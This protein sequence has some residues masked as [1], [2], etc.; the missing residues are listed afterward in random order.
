M[1]N[2]FIQYLRTLIKLAFGR[3]VRSSYAQNGEDAVILGSLKWVDKGVY[4]DVGA[5]H[6][7]LYS[8]TYALYKKGWQGIVID[9]NL[10]MK[11]LYSL[12]RPRDIFVHAAVGAREESIPYY[13]FSDGSYNG[14]DEERAKGWEASR[15]LCIKEVRMISFKPLSQILK[16]QNIRRIDFLNVDVEGLDLEVLKTHDWSILPRIIAI[17]DETFN[18]DKPHENAIYCYLNNKGYV[19]AGLAGLTLIFSKPKATL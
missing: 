10:D 19:L 12:L 18:P 11:P 6:P 9:P 14:F 7:A 8:N 17:E 1:V 2:T 15:G 16:E 4:V 13:M 5:Y 3:G